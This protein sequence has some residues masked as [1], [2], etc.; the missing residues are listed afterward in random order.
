[1]NNDLLNRKLTRKDFLKKT[2]L[3][4]LGAG[5]FFDFESRLQEAYAKGV[6]ISSL[7]EA[8]FYRVIDEQTVQCELCPRRCTLS[9]GQRSFCHAREARSGKLYS[10]VYGRPCSVAID[11]IEKKPFFHFLPGIPVFSIATAGCN[12]RCKYCQNWQISQ[13]PPEEVENYS[14]APEG[15]VKQAK[16]KDCP[17]IAYTYTD[18]VI[19]Y[20]YM[21]DTAK[22]AKASG[23]RN[24]C[25]TNGSFNPKPAL[26]I[27][28]YL[29]GANIDLKGFTQEFYTDVCSGFLDDTLNTLKTFK[30]HNVWVEITNLVIPTLNDDMGRIKEMCV[31]IKDNLGPDVP[32]HFSRFYPQYKLT[33]LTPTPVETLERAWQ[34]ALGTGLHYVYIGNV[35]G[36]PAEHTYCPQCKKNVIQRSGYTILSNNVVDGK[37]K[38]CTGKIAGVWN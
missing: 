5:L 18:P 29:D 30:E 36:H 21:L 19:F 15:V 27:A 28:P 34:I 9:N 6:G 13:Y 16:D 1:M 24:L 25:H 20:E 2:C 35:P 17:A 11:P 4:C 26:G 32:L 22:E 10:M 12:Y 7:H 23:I 38:F 37:C 3:F 33:G 31:W 14:L 8:A